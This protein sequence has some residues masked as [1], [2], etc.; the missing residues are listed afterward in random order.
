VLF[1]SALS[2]HTSFDTPVVVLRPFNTY[3][4]RQSARAVIPSVIIQILSGRRQIRLGALHPTRDFSFITDTAAGF[5]KALSAENVVGEVVNI[6]SGF[7]ISI[8]DTARTIAQVMETTIEVA[9]DDQRLRPEKSEVERLCASSEKA[10]RLL[11]WAPR[12]AGLDGFRR[13]L[14]HTV[15]WFRDSSNLARYKAEAYNL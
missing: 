11:G 1:R 9:R 8:A 10:R 2:F 6:G 5:V 7:E 14:A 3:G 12:F 13:G 15:D 4:P